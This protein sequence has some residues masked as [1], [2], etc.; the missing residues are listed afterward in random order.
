METTTPGKFT[1]GF[2]R[3]TSTQQEA[4]QLRT[5]ER[6]FIRRPWF[7]LVPDQM[8]KVVTA[9]YGTPTSQ[10]NVNSSNYVTTASTQDGWLVISYISQEAARSSSTWH[11]LGVTYTLAGT[12]C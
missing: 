2:G 9:G 7:R 6:L 11:A 12:T 1:G 4:T 10:G 3:A 5:L 8:H